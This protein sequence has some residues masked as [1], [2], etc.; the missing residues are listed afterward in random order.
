VLVPFLLIR[1]GT[2]A[3]IAVGRLAIV[4]LIALFSEHP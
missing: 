2:F 3:L 4:A 1:V